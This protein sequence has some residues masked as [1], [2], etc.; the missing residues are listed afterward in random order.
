MKKI[1]L[2]LLIALGLTG[3]LLTAQAYTDV[4]TDDDYS[5]AITW[6]TT[7]GV[8]QGYSDGTYQPDKDVNR[9]E[10]L[11]IL[12]LLKNSEPPSAPD[13]S[14][15]DDVALE[16]WYAPYVC[17][18]KNSGIVAGYT[19]NLFKPDQKIT[20]VEASKIIAL[21]LE[22]PLNSSINGTQWYS[23]YLESLADLSVYPT[24]LNY[25]TENV[26]RGGLAELLWRL[27]EKK[28]GFESTP[29]TGFSS[30]CTNFSYDIPSNVDIKT[31][32][33]TWL[34]WMNDTRAQ[35]GL[36]AYT[37]NDQLIRTA[38][39]WSEYNKARGYVNHKRPGTTAYYDYYAI[40]DWFQNLGLTF[41]NDA[42][43][44]FTENIGYGPYY[45]QTEDCTT[46]LLEAIRYTYDYYLSEAGSSYSP[47]W[48]S[49]VASRFKQVGLGLTV[50]EDTYYLTVHY[51]TSIS[52]NPPPL[53]NA[54]Y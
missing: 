19:G 33:S 34:K 11:K 2:F 26:T 6:L 27:E 54:L 7:Q 36:A 48:N 44:T 10:L 8:V 18:A 42:G 52:S 15:F 30:D 29:W 5:E 23:P 53:C 31:I 25:L 45:C 22:V 39:V 51:A 43:Y 49:I 37:Y 3:T 28:T 47:H 14:C 46:D 50:D 12:L 17:S 24:E 32:E 13:S 38:T 21:T 4:S 16:A 1:L 20:V 40:E 9:A 41:K 35:Q